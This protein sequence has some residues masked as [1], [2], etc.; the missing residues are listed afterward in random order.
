MRTVAVLA[1]GL[2]TTACDSILGIP[3][4]ETLGDGG[5]EGSV[6]T[7]PQCNPDADFNSKCFQCTDVS[8]CG[9]YVA[10]HDDPR[11]GDYYKTCLPNCTAQDASFNDCVVRC[12]KQYGAGHAL[13]APY[14]ACTLRHCLGPCSNGPPDPCIA[15]LYAS[16]GD[17]T[18]ACDSDR[19]CDTLL[20][21][22]A[23]CNGQLNADSCSAACKAGVSQRAQSELS[24]QV[25]CAITYCQKSCA[26]Q[27]PGQ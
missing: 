25:A 16:C 1:V 20:S 7:S 6:F 13:N 15:C 12:D 18:Y 3:S 22:T 17:S 8:C 23:S 21:C 14:S 27:L 4:Q 24:A 11:C 10:C 19:E 5:D 26:G 2:L 9:E